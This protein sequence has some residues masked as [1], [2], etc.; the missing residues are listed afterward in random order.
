MSDTG[1][2]TFNAQQP[3]GPLSR[4]KANIN[5]GAV[6][7]ITGPMALFGA[8]ETAAA[9]DDAANTALGTSN[10]RFDT[11]PAAATA[12]AVGSALVGIPAGA[13]AAIARAAPYIGRLAAAVPRPVARVAEAVTPL[14]L[15]LT[16]AGVAAN[17]VGG[18]VVGVGAEQLGKWLESDAPDRPT[19]D[20]IEAAPSTVAQDRGSTPQRTAY[21]A[22]EWISPDAP[23]APAAAAPVA[24]ALAA[25]AGSGNSAM[26]ADGW[27]SPEGVANAAAD[28]SQVP[29]TTGEKVMGYLPYA[30]L[31]TGAAAGVRLSMRQAQQR[32]DASAAFRNSEVN[33]GNPRDQEV[34][35]PGFWR[36]LANETVDEGATLQ[37]VIDD[38]SKA[39]F[40]GPE[41]A[42]V[43][44]AAVDVGTNRTARSGR[45][46]EVQR[47]GVLTDGHK[48]PSS[49]R[50]WI[51]EHRQVA[52]ADPGKAAKI[53][54]AH[55]FA[56]ELANR[57]R[58]AELVKYTDYTDP[59]TGQRAAVT[60]RQLD[61]ATGQYSDVYDVDKVTGAQTLR[62]MPEP[63]RVG[64]QDVSYTDMHKRYAELLQDPDVAKSLQQ[65]KERA[66]AWRDFLVRNNALSASDAAQMAAR[67]PYYLPTLD[68]EEGAGKHFNRRQ[69][70]ENAAPRKGQDM[71]QSWAEYEQEAIAYALHNSAKRT[72]ANFLHDYQQTLP[73]GK[74]NSKFV[75]R[76]LPMGERETQSNNFISFRDG[77]KRVKLEVFTPEIAAVMRNEPKNLIPY[78]NGMRQSMQYFT[79]GPG[80]AFLGSVF[81]PVSAA[82]NLGTGL[83][84]RA[85]GT[86]FGV[87]D[88][89]VQRVTGGRMGVRGDPTALLQSLYSVAADWSSLGARELANSS[90]LR[91]Y[92]PGGAD[93]LK[94][95]YEQSVL[96]QS[97]LLGAVNTGGAYG[98]D[99]STRSRA[100]LGGIHPGYDATRPVTSDR[101]RSYDEWKE[102]YRQAG[103]TVMPAAARKS[104]QIVKEAM[105]I[106]S[107]SPQS[108]YFRQNR[109]TMQQ[110]YTA[111]GL[112]V[113]DADIALSR[114]T[115]QLGADPSLAGAS[116]AVQAITSAM[117]YSNI[118]L[119]S[120]ATY[121]K[122]FWENPYGTIAGVGI[123]ALQLALLRTYSAMVYDEDR[124]A[125]GQQPE[126]VQHL[127]TASPQEQIR[128]SK[129]YMAGLPVDMAASLPIEPLLGPAVQ[130][131]T[132]LAVNV[133][134]L[135]DPRFFTPE[136]AENREALRAMLDGGETRTLFESVVRPTQLSLPPVIDA[137]LRLGGVDARNFV[138]LDS[139]LQDVSN[140]H[141]RGY[142][143][144][145]VPNDPIPDSLRNVAEAMAGAAGTLAV[146]MARTALL[147]YRETG[148]VGTAVNAMREQRAMTVED[149][150]NMVPS[151][152]G[153]HYQQRRS[154]YDVNAAEVA[155][156]SK[157]LEAVSQQM[158]N[159]SR[160]G[161]IGSGAYTE[162]SQLGG[163]RPRP[164]EGNIALIQQFNQLKREI[165][166]LKQEASA[167]RD[168]I[169]ELRG[170][171]TRLASPRDVRAYENRI[172]EDI[173]RINAAIVQRVVD[174]ERW[175][176]QQYGRK[177]RLST[178]DP[179][180]ARGVQQF[181][182]A[183]V[184]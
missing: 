43:L 153:D 182:A 71:F 48:L 67:N 41:Q 3:L 13:G 7:A 113:A 45:A 85:K 57:H 93:W 27:I 28:V 94:Q 78:L 15:P 19:T 81:A 159:I 83:A 163:G 97:N 62:T 142:T 99:Y 106:V 151:L 129:F 16:P 143:H 64:L 178:F 156:V 124:I 125:N 164:P 169:N 40:I 32:R 175:L 9:I 171:G 23:T 170:S 158:P 61:P 87:L 47:T 30:L 59:A 98:G 104:W 173:R 123:T 24:G 165:E 131:L 157:R 56:N 119:Q 8:D 136:L 36:S 4:L 128:A 86:S 115:R 121:G 38:A 39:Q 33:P 132:Q 77:G 10:A 145:A 107:N 1:W 84:T 147:V 5:R 68:Y 52:A 34:H 60:A 172:N 79:T 89:V 101:P 118:M 148:D 76:I 72:V 102:Q 91:K 168:R 130:V 6:G 75:G 140:R 82:Y 42:E 51:E 103:Y 54:E 141:S 11:D 46:Q 144:G 100:D 50:D 110:R 2:L 114:R 166:P 29:L 18:T 176:S 63:A 26:S 25:A 184:Q 69:I 37:G 109:D 14:T 65:G 138:S 73:Q 152:W 31:G 92:V 112:T 133:F 88:Q 58:A 105:D 53:Q 20:W 134:G 108:A 49:L 174:K 117:P 122:A 126:A 70:E 80:A 35:A 135:K 167:N 120:F 177:V 183:E 160:P 154:G 21:A 155:D 90:V 44:R 95:Q 139:R 17:A 181:D 12:Q 111:K 161:T 179:T 150:L 116:S 149:R 74:T 146:Q 137:G 55:A 180:D 66:A 22:T 162:L 127:L 96:H